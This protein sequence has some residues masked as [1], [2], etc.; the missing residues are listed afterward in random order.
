MSAEP[1]WLTEQEQ[2]A[3]R[4][5]V[6]LWTQLSAALARDMA[7]HS[8][9]SMADFTVLVALT[10]AC[11]GRVRAYSLAETLQWERSRLSHQLSRMERRGLLTRDA[12]SED[13]R[14]Q[15]VCVSAAGRTAIGAAAPAHVAAVRRLFLDAL[16][17]D[18]VAA[19]AEIVA[20][21]LPRLDDTSAAPAAGG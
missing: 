12:C 1:R 10:E 11:G 7:A 3:W 15:V 5:L 4:G 17:A 16:N 21:A 19:L 14:G 20:L 18:Q 2:Q 8:E 13:G 6:T 9:L